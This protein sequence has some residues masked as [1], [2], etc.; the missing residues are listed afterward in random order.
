MNKGRLFM[1]SILIALAMTSTVYAKDDILNLDLAVKNA[2]NS[3][4]SIKKKEI[5]I[6]T[7][8]NSLKDQMHTSKLADRA[9]KSGSKSEDEMYMLLKLRDDSIA[10]IEFN[11]FQEK[12]ALEVEKN[13][14]KQ[15]VYES[16]ADLLKS[17]DALQIEKIAMDNHKKQ[18]EKSKMLLN[19][20]AIG[21]KEFNLVE[22]KYLS[23]K[24]NY[25]VCDRDF[26]EKC[27][28]FNKLIGQP[29]NKSYLYEKDFL[30]SNETIKPLDN[31]INEALKNR[32]EIINGEEF[33][34][35]KRFEEGSAY[36]IY[37]NQYHRE[38]KMAETYVENAKDSLAMKKLD[39]QMEINDIYNNL[40]I[41]LKKLSI[42]E[43]NYNNKNKKFQELKKKYELGSISLLDLNMY[44]EEFLKSTLNYKNLKRDI[45]MDIMKLNDATT[46]GNNASKV[47]Y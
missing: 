7:L 6:K 23:D 41:N 33:V 43:K 17:R 21:K 45:Y 38:R 46:I 47:L 2:I 25:N 19:L 34:R 36:G 5:N 22:T 26:K 42:E 9:M 28:E 11:I 31:Y 24:G 14:V 40:Q 27:I 15:L 3:S 32:M 20:G 29:L 1:S 37:K 18:Y 10:N 4:Y 30:N 44:K 13:N 39:I 12:N 8:N 16:Y 35:L